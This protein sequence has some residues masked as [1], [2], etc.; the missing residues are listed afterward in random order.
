MRPETAPA[1]RLE[2][3]APAA[4]RID[5]VHLDV[6]LNP[7][8][9]TVDARLVV[10]PAE[11][12]P[13]G[14]T[15]VLDGDGLDFTGLLLNGLPVAPELV[16]ASP[17]KL[18]LRD[19]PAGPF[20]L[21]IQTR[22]DPEA[23]TALMGLYRTSG[24]YC[25]QCEAEGFRRITYFLDRPDVLAVYT[26]RLEARQSDAPILLG[27]GNPVEAGPVPGTDRHYAVWHDPFPKPSYLFA[28]VA[29]N[30]ACVSDTFVTR[31]GNKVD[32]NIYVEHGR[33]GLCAWA[34]DSLKRSMAWDEEAYGREYDLEVFNIVAVSDFNMGAM[35]NKGLNIF[36][37]KYILADPE[38]ATD[39]DYANIE[40]V[41]AHEY[42]HNWTGNRITCRDWF[43]LCLKEGLTVFRDQEFSSDMRS[44]PVKRIADVR[45]LKAHQ[46]PED[47]GPLAH[48]VRP[49]SYKEINN[50]YTA[51]VYEKGAEVVRMLKTLLGD[52]GFRRGMDLYF[53]RH[54]GEATTIEAFLTCFSEAA[55]TDLGQFARWYDQAGTPKVSVKSHYDSPAQTLTLTFGQS[56]PPLPDQDT[57]EPSVIP[58]RFALMDPDGGEM[59][60]KHI[61][62]ATIQ[63]DVLLLEDERQT[64]SFS[65]L[66]KP[67]TV[68]L[69][70]GFSAP[71][72][73]EFDQSVEEH[74]F[75]ARHDTDPFNRW[76]AIQNVA[77]QELM[78]LTQAARTGRT[79][80]TDTRLVSAFGD[81]AENADLDPAF[82]AQALTLPSEL[83]IARDLGRDVDP[84]A[85]HAAHRNLSRAIAD[86]NEAQLKAAAAAPPNGPFSPDAASAGRRALSNKALT[87][88]AAS[89]DPEAASLVRARFE[90]ANNMTDRMAALT[91]LVHLNLDGADEALT[92]FKQRHRGASLALDKWFQVQAT[93]PRPDSIARLN[94]LMRDPLYDA[95]NPNRI[96]ALVQSFA[97]G[98]PTQFARA[99]GSGFDLVAEAVIAIDPRNPQVASRLLTSYRS[100]RALEKTRAAQAE[101]ALIRI[102][103]IGKLSR[104]S[105]D[106]VDRC[107]Q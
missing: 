24:T 11:G 50:F 44:R 3:Y 37:D 79:L 22:L 77:T 82:R 39:Q 40:A 12:T 87:Y 100:W 27:N 76:Q 84:D 74:L 14:Q 69:L 9:T 68:S 32:L 51:T 1:I 86:T 49:K 36:N 6:K 88:L 56:I 103:K 57:S 31:S 70:R 94:E 80:E 18:E 4:Y 13:A 35:E 2:D 61:T 23:N 20:T 55:A 28:L 62:G 78:R 34:M 99:D 106:I 58:L 89:S 46:F 45:L 93:A 92:A 83:D 67:P 105:R 38:T 19:P 75:L 96:R 17:D 25:T 64:V 10:V 42:F 54:D 29:G 71:V 7:K 95:A 72:R 59:V 26:T 102:S 104:D 63:H 98:N 53:E 16:D 21:E 47:A 101:A 41:I 30:L 33:E 60:P 85:I 8:A 65:G 107:L 52:D 81:I 15:L 43:Q 90:T 48:P 91:V 5:T 97:T 66:P 73:L